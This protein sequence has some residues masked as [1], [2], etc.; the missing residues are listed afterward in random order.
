VLG[1]ALNYAS[2]IVDK[3]LSSAVRIFRILNRIE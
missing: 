2:T 1:E 3:L